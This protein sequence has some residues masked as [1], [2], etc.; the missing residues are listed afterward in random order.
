VKL[1]IR[2]HVR[3]V[4]AIVVMLALFLG[5]AGYILAR[6]TSFVAPSWLP[7]FGKSYYTV[8]AD[9]ATA[10][11]IVPG[12]GQTV[13]VSG[14]E[15]GTVSGAQLRD[16]VAQVTLQLE[17]KYA[18]IYR[19]ATL[20]LRPRTPLND[21]FIALDPGTP[22]AG[23]LP[24]GGVLPASQT[25][26]DVN[27]DEI[28]ANLDGDTRSYL[29]LLLAAGGQALP[30]P[31]AT[32]DLRGVLKRLDP[33]TVDTRAVAGALAARRLNLARAIHSFSQ[34]AVSLGGT[35]SQLARLVDAADRGF[36]A[37]AAQDANLRAAIAELPG[38]A[39]AR[40]A[41]AGQ[42]FDAR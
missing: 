37:T 8:R 29:E 35:D 24:N 34:I 15:V 5:C 19:N 2:R 9:F 1:A 17:Q 3:D 21:M 31:G 41:S 36:A 28:L 20:L 12:Q 25:N 42:A 13:N 30:G 10:N 18:P 4:V 40:P 33:L 7:F 14:V 16:G 6:Q 32:A 27:V 39:W 23:A 26:P 11:A 38:D 22:A